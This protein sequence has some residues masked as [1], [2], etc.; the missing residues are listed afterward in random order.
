[1]SKKSTKTTT[2]T[3][4]SLK[5]EEIICRQDENGDL[6]LEWSKDHPKA[7][8]LNSWTQED[9][10]AAL[11][12]YIKKSKINGKQAG[13]GLSEEISSEPSDAEGIARKEA[14]AKAKRRK[15]TSS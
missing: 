4:S 3:K 12:T 8:I 10:V 13:Q 5:N 15:S 2:R 9:F 1:M 7:H 6:I 14:P 11:T